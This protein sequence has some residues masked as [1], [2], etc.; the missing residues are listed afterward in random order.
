[1]S[2]IYLAEKSQLDSIGGSFCTCS[3]AAA[4][5][6]KTASLSNFTLKT[7]AQVAVKFTYANTASSPTLNI[8]GTGAKSIYYH[9]SA[10]PVSMLMSGGVYLF[11]YDG[12][13][14]QLLGNHFAGSDSNSLGACQFYEE[15]KG[16]YYS[17]DYLTFSG[18]SP[19]GQ[20]FTPSTGS[21]SGK[22]SVTCCYGKINFGQYV[23]QGYK[24]LLINV[25]S[26]CF[27]DGY[28]YFYISTSSGTSY[29]DTS[30][31][32]VSAGFQKESSGAIATTT[33]KACLLDISN[34]SGSYYFIVALKKGG[35][36]NSFNFEAGSIYLLT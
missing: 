12:S 8:N 5:A 27:G 16:K 32:V 28:G 1:M 26:A 30:G 4:T 17:G 9:N 31:V 25:V 36:S 22:S 10:V 13:R 33:T 18:S 23:K 34:L 19:E 14:W 6:A 2:K 7:G 29:S 15:L 11:V 20:F 3:T 24:K 35:S 21:N